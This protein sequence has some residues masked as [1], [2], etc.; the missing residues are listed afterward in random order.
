MISA[1]A[2]DRFAATA[3]PPELGHEVRHALVEFL[4]EGHAPAGATLLEAG[5][6]NDRVHFLLEGRLEFWRHYA[7][8]GEERITTLDAPSVFG[9]T[10]FF[11]PNPP[12]VTVRSETPSWFL[13]L[14][15]AAYETFRGRDPRAAEQFLRAALRVLAERFDLLDQ[16]LAEFLNHHDR[17]RFNEWNEFRARIFREA[18]F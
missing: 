8:H 11:G 4:E 15:E 14:T 9:V 6:P 13:Y 17:R 1:Q 5:R 10:S 7:G 18:S 3:W 16:R 12:L 2:A